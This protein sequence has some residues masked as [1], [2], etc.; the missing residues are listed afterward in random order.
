MDKCLC[1]DAVANRLH[2]SRD[3][4]GKMFREAYSKSF[5]DYLTEVRLQKA[6]EYMDNSRMSITGILDEIGW[7]NKN[8]FYTTFKLKYGITTSQYRNMNTNNL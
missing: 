4:L 3:Y 5:A 6:V 7:E 8:Y 1:Q 2:I